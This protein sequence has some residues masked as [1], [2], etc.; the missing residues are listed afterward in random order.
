MI[1]L[2]VNGEIRPAHDLVVVIP[3]CGRAEL[4][5]RTLQ[6][7]E[8]CDK[9]PTYRET[10]VVENGPKGDAE[11]IVADFR[12]TLRSRHV[13][14]APP[15]KSAA[16][17]RVIEMLDDDLVVFLD[18][19]VRPAPELLVAYDAAAR[20]VRR[21]SFFG[22]PFEIDYEQAPPRHIRCFLPR[23]ARGWERPP[24]LAPGREPFLGFNWAAFVPDLRDAGC[25][26][27]DRG[28]GAA[29]GMTV[30]DESLLQRRMIGRGVQ[31]VYVAEARVWHY[32][33]RERCS[34][35]WLLDRNF[36]HGLA[37]G[38]QRGGEQPALL[39][40]PLWMY[41]R[42]AQG[43]VK[44]LAEWL[45]FS[46]RLR[47]RWQHRTAFNRGL[48]AGATRKHAEELVTARARSRAVGQNGDVQA[49]PAAARLTGGHR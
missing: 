32:V 28:P 47:F 48:W 46:P 38:W 17:N 27:V 22:G 15:G 11:A 26:D 36:R 2:L 16:L 20:R 19:D 29:S 39:G 21:K 41:Q 34:A 43:F 45:T 42:R 30:G 33:P 8:V 44:G 24:G 5:R 6:C 35:E 40:R 12:A 23:S 9:P 1:S 10:I 31:E 3:T 7:I 13:Y 18:D 14:V 4:L 49:A 37:K 25:F